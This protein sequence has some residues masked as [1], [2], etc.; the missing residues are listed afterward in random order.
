MVQ[1]YN[2]VGIN[3][4]L[5]AL[6]L[7]FILCATFILFMKLQSSL[8]GGL[9]FL[10][11]FW[12]VILITS[13]EMFLGK[14]NLINRFRQTSVGR[15][16]NGYK[17][18]INDLWYILFIQISQFK[19]LIVIFTLGISQVQ[20]SFT[21]IFDKFYSEH[22]GRY[23]DGLNSIFILLILLL[24]IDFTEYLVHRFQHYVPLFWQFHEC[25]HSAPQMTLLNN[26]RDVV[27]N[28]LSF[29]A[30][31]PL[32]SF[33][34]LLV[35]HYANIDGYV[36]PIYILGTYNA[37]T[38]LTNYL[39][40]TSTKIIYPKFTSWFLL[41]PSLHWI[42]H[43][44]NPSHFDKNFGTLLSVWDIIFGTYLSEEHIKDID[45][46]GI[47][48]SEYE[49]YHPIY[50]ATVLPVIKAYKLIK[51]SFSTRQLNRIFVRT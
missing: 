14:G 24:I 36:L 51:L 40:H 32:Y 29:G 50:C 26:F 22:F 38:T 30:L 17:N 21:S 8:I 46:F 5:K 10:Q 43:S 20:K 25:H 39:G 12:P 27:L 2:L 48:N 7:F 45:G 15:T 33:T 31:I 6:P 49:K 41:S 9:V 19:G 47:H 34:S 28:V 44:T 37:L 23:L 42:H 18:Q 3:K 16:S 11:L 1:I 13:Y 35:V 4:S